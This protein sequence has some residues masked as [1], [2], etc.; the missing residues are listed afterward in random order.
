MTRLRHT[1]TNWGWNKHSALHCYKFEC[2][3]CNIHSPTDCTCW[4]ILT[5]SKYFALFGIKHWHWP[6]LKSTIQIP[7]DLQSKASLHPPF[8]LICESM[9]H[10]CALQQINNLKPHAQV[11]FIILVSKSNLKK[12]VWHMKKYL[13]K[14]SL[15]HE[16]I[17]VNSCD[18]RSGKL[19]C[20]SAHK[21][22]FSKMHWREMYLEL[23]GWMTYTTSKDSLLTY[24]KYST[25]N[26]T[27]WY[28]QDIHV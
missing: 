27:I 18:S 8:C 22:F 23:Q 14:Y 25:P 1:Q 2:H 21:S 11:Y 5:D 24:S 7:V 6:I 9:K 13:K 26:T 17:S 16:E 19:K 10:G 12:A 20:W 15:A 28:S 4:T 3:K